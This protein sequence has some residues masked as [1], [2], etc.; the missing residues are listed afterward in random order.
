MANNFPTLS[1]LDNMRLARLAS[2]A[3]KVSSKAEE[4]LVHSLRRGLPESTYARAE[5]FFSRQAQ[6]TTQMPV[7]DGTAFRSS[8]DVAKIAVQPCSDEQP[9]VG[10]KRPRDPSDGCD[11]PGSD[12]R[13]SKIGPPRIAVGHENYKGQESVKRPRLTVQNDVAGLSPQSIA[14]AALISQS[15]NNPTAAARSPLTPS[16]ANLLSTGN[17]DPLKECSRPKLS[18]SNA[19][20]GNLGA[21]A[22]SSDLGVSSKAAVNQSPPRFARPFPFREAQSLNE[23]SSPRIIDRRRARNEELRRRFMKKRMDQ[24][25][26]G[27]TQA[28]KPEIDGRDQDASDS[29]DSVIKE[30]AQ[31]DTPDSGTSQISTTSLSNISD[32]PA[33]LRSLLNAEP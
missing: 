20:S 32:P 24:R 30:T 7:V 4:E 14:V 18:A 23:Q 19:D 13:P 17:R 12:Y 21:D 29:T 1:L 6:V 27:E 9:R 25:L 15:L 8:R 31:A 26:A 11:Q 10:Q 3:R 22:S 33:S 2:V 5:T 16:N 28:V